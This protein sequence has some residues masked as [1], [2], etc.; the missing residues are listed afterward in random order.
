MG[1]SNVAFV[2]V[3]FMGWEARRVKS[4]SY[5][6]FCKELNV[7]YERQILTEGMG[8]HKN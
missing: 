8:S 6:F 7:F 1:D 4:K 2:L 3:V 5:G